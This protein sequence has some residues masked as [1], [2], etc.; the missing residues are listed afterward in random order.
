MSLE[1]IILIPLQPMIWMY[2]LLCGTESMFDALQWLIEF[3]Y[4][5]LI[6][7]HTC[8]NFFKFSVYN[9]FKMQK[10]AARAYLK[11]TEKN[12]CT[13][14]GLYN[15]HRPLFNMLDFA[16]FSRWHSLVTK[17]FL[18]WEQLPSYLYQ[19]GTFS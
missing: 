18:C 6:I 15:N 11:L 8:Y 7:K 5:Y 14:F 10:T 9:L 19:E 12:Y 4:I 16:I 2:G 1:N 17:K 3:C 13:S